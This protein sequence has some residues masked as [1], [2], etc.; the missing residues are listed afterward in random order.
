M[1]YDCLSVQLNYTWARERDLWVSDD[2]GRYGE[3]L[4]IPVSN[5]RSDAPR[6]NMRYLYRI[7]ELADSPLRCVRCDGILQPGTHF[8]RAY[9]AERGFGTTCGDCEAAPGYLGGGLVPGRLA[10]VTGQAERSRAGADRLTTLGC[11]G[12]PAGTP[13]DW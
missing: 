13:A 7:A 9:N 3:P 2:R 5:D 6:A 4:T 8:Y 12:A 11:R 1:V 10:A